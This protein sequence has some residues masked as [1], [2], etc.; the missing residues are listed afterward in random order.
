MSDT[1]HIDDRNWL[2]ERFEQR[3]AR[4]RAVAYRMLGSVSE[5]DD[6]LQ[7]VWLRFS[8]TDTSAVEQLDAWLTTVV[9][10]VCL[11]MLRSRERR[12]EELFGLQLPDPIVDDAGPEDEAML[13]DSVGLALLVVLET[14]SPAERL[15]FVLH[16]L[17]AVPF[18][19]IAAM[20]DSTPDAAR[21]LASRAR[22]R[23]RGSAP[24]PDP[25][26]ALRQEVV[27]AFFAA[28]RDGEF[29]RLVELLHPEVIARADRGPGRTLTIRGAERVARA[30]L[31]GARRDRQLR[32]TVVNGNPG[33][34]VF[35]AGQPVLLMAFTVADGRIAEIDSYS[36]SEPFRRSTTEAAR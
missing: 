15:A 7:E 6:A 3:R 13:A 1:P 18:A 25:D 30:A 8:R 29:D 26:P 36:L 33:A 24:A 27:T 32:P 20:L 16:D 17:F 31:V 34:I 9:G 19:D 35:E 12:R 23:V 14:L 22:R 28:A 4:L 10:R 21:K 5:A 2:V 11:D